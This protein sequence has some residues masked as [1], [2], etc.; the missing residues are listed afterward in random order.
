VLP[1]DPKESYATLLPPPQCH[2]AFSTMLRTLAL[3]EQSPVCHPRILLP[4]QQGC[5]WLDFGGV[6]N[7]T[8]YSYIVSVFYHRL[9]STLFFSGTSIHSLYHN[10]SCLLH[11]KHTY[12]FKVTILI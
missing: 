3:V 9:H 11:Y 6:L 4:P 8:F 12:E 1:S 2:A 5:L 7:Y 10:L